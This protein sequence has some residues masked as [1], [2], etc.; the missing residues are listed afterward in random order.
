MVS[1]GVEFVWPE[2]LDEDE[3]DQLLAHWGH[4]GLNLGDFLFGVGAVEEVEPIVLVPLDQVD[5]PVE[6]RV[7]GQLLYL[8]QL[9]LVEKP[10]EELGGEARCKHSCRLYHGIKEGFFFRFEL[11][12]HEFEAEDDEIL[13]QERVGDPQEYPLEN[14]TVNGILPLLVVLSIN[15]PQLLITVQQFKDSV[16]EESETILIQVMETRHALQGEVDLARGLS[17]RLITIGYVL[18]LSHNSVGFL[19]LLGDLTGFCL[20]LLQ[21]RDD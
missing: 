7:L 13:G 19:H 10:A 9:L 8:L 3:T 5:E 20:Q 6:D 4:F 17:D 11:N 1:D 15:L 2:N 21:G 18:H 14:S 12:G 16:H